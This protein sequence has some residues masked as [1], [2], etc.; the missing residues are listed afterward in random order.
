MSDEVQ[1]DDPGAIP[2]RYT[3]Q[4]HLRSEGD[5]V[6]VYLASRQDSPLSLE[7]HL[8]TVP[9]AEDEALANRFIDVARQMA[10]VRHRAVMP[11]H[12]LGLTGGRVYFVTPALDATPLATVLELDGGTLTPD[13]V[14]EIAQDLAEGLAAV[15]AEG[16]VHRSISEDSVFVS[17][18]GQ[19]YFGECAAMRSFDVCLDPEMARTLHT[20]RASPEEMLGLP[21]TTR[22]DVFHLAALLYRCLLGRSCL[23]VGARVPTRPGGT[24]VALPTAEETQGW[25]PALAEAITAGLAWNPKDRPEDGAA[26][27]SRLRDLI[28]DDPLQ[29]LMGGVEEEE[30]AAS[31]QAREAAATSAEEARPA[32]PST[33]ASEDVAATPASDPASAPP[34]RGPAAALPP[35]T[36]LQV[37]GG[38]VIGLL[39]IATG[40]L[41]V[42]DYL[43]SGEGPATVATAESTPQMIRPVSA[44]AE[45]TLAEAAVDAATLPTDAETFGPRSMVLRDWIREGG[46]VAKK[47]SFRYGD[48]LKLRF[49]GARGNSEAHLTLDRWLEEWRGTQIAR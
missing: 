10:R 17:R 36:E 15:H 13:R 31:E 47:L 39:A 40:F 5:L 23:E 18:H 28:S 41:L 32:A 35:G 6:E 1:P 20:S 46:P 38:Y 9:G 42:P 22:T 11:V 21:D 37:R 33:P 30:R 43:A 44:S 14:A 25:P 26:F 8:L 7:L 16:I 4:R 24:G 48:V 29:A 3:V 49:E 12:D 19:V 27:A 34:A 2:K 45:V